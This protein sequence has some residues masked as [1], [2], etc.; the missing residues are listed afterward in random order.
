MMISR[1][2]FTALETNRP[3]VQNGPIVQG[4]TLYLDGDGLAY[5][6]SG[7]D[8]TSRAE[9]MGNLEGFILEKLRLSRAQRGVILVTAPESHKGYRYAVATVKPYQGNRN[10]GRRPKN[11]E[12][13]RNALLGNASLFGFAIKTTDTYEADDLFGILAK[14][15][16][17]ICTQDKDMRM[18]PATHMDW[19]DNHFVATGGHTWECRHYGTVYGRKWFW[20]Q[21]LMGDTADNIPGL[22]RLNGKLCGEVTA[23][24]Y[25]RAARFEK[26]A[27]LLVHE[28]YFKHYGEQAIQMMCEQA[29]LLW[30]R[31]QPDVLDVF[32]KTYGP[33]KYLGQEALD[34]GR[35]YI[36]KVISEQTQDN[37]NSK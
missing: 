33:L 27:A 29:F 14:A 5:F 16:D 2:K 25:L 20:L 15:D 30:M 31:W 3:M 21:M 34:I 17:V 7:S 26:D 36:T 24:H 1:D 13:L 12:A 4:R 19:H 37:W 28:A 35:A 9:A 32:N 10:S 8:T 18:V 6:C 23:K 11:W 22:P